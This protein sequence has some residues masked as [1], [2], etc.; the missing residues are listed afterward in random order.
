MMTTTAIAFD[1]RYSLNT[2]W[3]FHYGAM[4]R[5]SAPCD[6][7]IGRNVGTGSIATAVTATADACC[8]ACYA[9]ERCVAWDWVTTGSAT[10]YMK[11]NAN[12][13]V[14]EA[15]R[16]TGV[17]PLAPQP[18]APG[19]NDSDW[20][21]DVILPHDYSINGTFAASNDDYYGY[22]PHPPAW[23][24]KN[25][26]VD[27]SLQGGTLFLLV[28]SAMRN[29][30]VWLNGVELGD[31]T[32]HTSGYAS[33]GYY[34]TDAV[35]YGDAT[36]NVLA[37]YVDPSN[38]EGAWYVARVVNAKSDEAVTRSEWL[39]IPALLPLPCLSLFQYICAGGMKARACY[40]RGGSTGPPPLFTFQPLVV[41]LFVRM[42]LV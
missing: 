33:W 4:N 23:Y 21:H 12:G 37:V 1:T 38:T 39:P 28:D 6:A 42:S 41:L 9:N 16:V 34:V 15:G 31:G 29:A 19:F 2:A 20:L 17:V 35:L 11:D 22:L 7:S 27:P 3:R 24:R 40:D 13:N 30:R 36:E 8:Q 25:F 5:S 14:S 18:T 26:T 32:P 10:C